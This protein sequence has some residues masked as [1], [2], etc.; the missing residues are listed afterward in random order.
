ML[1]DGVLGGRKEGLYMCFFKITFMC[2]S[3]YKCNLPLCLHMHLKPRFTLL[4]DFDFN[5][6]SDFWRKTPRKLHYMCL[7]QTEANSTF[8]F[9]S[10]SFSQEVILKRA[11]DL[12]EAL[13]GLPHN[14]QVRNTHTRKHL[15]EKRMRRK[16]YFSYRVYGNSSFVLVGDHPEA[17][18]GHCRSSLQRPS[19]THP[20]LRLH[21]RRHDGCQLLHWAA[22]RQRL[23]THTSQSG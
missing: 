8:F 23:W 19:R 6:F 1:V 22:V 7:L 14:N 10:L 17:C 9:S 16:C 13:Y 11:A 3:F 15:Q 18:G 20:A 2:D 12:V 5:V 4:V 21:P